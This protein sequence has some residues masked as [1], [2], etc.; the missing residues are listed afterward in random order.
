MTRCT[1]CGKEFNGWNDL[2][3]QCVEDNDDYYDDEDA[4]SA[5]DPELLRTWGKDGSED[6]GWEDESESRG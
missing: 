3:P 1:E 6:F 5:F 4:D 2:C